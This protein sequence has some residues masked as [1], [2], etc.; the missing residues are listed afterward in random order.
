MSALGSLHSYTPSTRGAVN[1]CLW[2]TLLCLVFVMRL[3]A[4]TSKLATRPG[5]ARV[6]ELIMPK[7]Y[8]LLKDHI[9]KNG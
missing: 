1:Y 3:I 7:M 2:V 4:I 8:C 5:F 9:L 6:I